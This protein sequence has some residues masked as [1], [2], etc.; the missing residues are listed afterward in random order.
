MVIF[1]I[2]VGLV[3]FAAGLSI[4]IPLA[5]RALLGWYVREVKRVEVAEAPDEAIVTYPLA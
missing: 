1:D 3:G 5:R 2:V 4:G